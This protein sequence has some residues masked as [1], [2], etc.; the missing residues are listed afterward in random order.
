MDPSSINLT[1]FFADSSASYY[2]SLLSIAVPIDSLLSIAG[3]CRGILMAPALGSLG[4]YFS[5]KRTFASSVAVSG[6]SIGL[7]MVPLVL[8]V[9]L[10]EYSIPGAT[11]ILG[12]V[13]LHGCILGT[14][15]RP[16]I[17]V[18]IEQSVE[19][20]L[21]DVQLSSLDEQQEP[22]NINQ[23][24]LEV[25]MSN[26]TTSPCS[27]FLRE[28]AFL[29]N[30]L[31]LRN[32]AAIWFCGMLYINWS[33]FLPAYVNEIGLSKTDASIF[34]S[35]TGISTLVTRP[36]GGYIITRTGINKTVVLLVCC[37]VAS[38]ACMAFAFLPMIIGYDL[39][40]TFWSLAL[41]SVIIAI[42]GNYYS[43][44]MMPLVVDAV[45]VKDLGRAVGMLPMVTGCGVA[46]GTQVFSKHEI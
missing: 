3:L 27:R 8:R 28:V 12:G 46:V 34:L 23:P 17:P 42:T 29:A 16:L 9:V 40:P 14:A 7:I 35:L 41:L 24:N 39:V 36:M 4:R 10:T 22:L 45:A 15:L 38:L 25:T 43:A 21:K 37:C 30:P 11:A 6:G 26:Q 13:I 1:T 33:I 31:L 2:S 18:T 5:S 20:E 32:L 19:S 44:L